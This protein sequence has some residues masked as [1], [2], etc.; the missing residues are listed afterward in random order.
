MNLVA[1]QF[2]NFYKTLNSLPHSNSAFLQ[3]E[4]SFELDLYE[5]SKNLE[6][7]L[8]FLVKALTKFLLFLIF[9]L[10]NGMTLNKWVIYSYEVLLSST[11]DLLQCLLSLYLKCSFLTDYDLSASKA[12]LNQLIKWVAA[13]TN[14]GSALVPKSAKA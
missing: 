6:L 1:M 13:L 8:I 3:F 4:A 12:A 7:M 11:N 14:F 10:K 5:A 2:L 9:L